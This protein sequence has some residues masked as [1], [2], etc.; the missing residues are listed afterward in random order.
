MTIRD[1]CA[2]IESWA[3]PAIAWEKDNV[4]LLVGSPDARVRKVLVCLDVTPEVVAEAVRARAGLIVSHHPLIF[5]PL[6]RLDPDTPRG[7]MIAALL[8]HGIGL[9]AAHTNLDFTAGGVSH[10]LAASLGLREIAP[11]APLRGRERKIAVFV[12]A[13]HAGGVMQAMAGAGAGVIGKYE[14][15]SFTTEG[16]G[17]FLAGPGSNPFIGKRGALERVGETKLEMS[18]PSWRVDAVVRAMKAAH[19]YDEVAFDVYVLENASRDH[20]MGAVGS[21]RRPLGLRAF[22]KM[23]SVRLGARALRYSGPSGAR[24]RRVA[25]CGGS[26]SELLGDA[27]RSGAD[28]FVTADVRYHAFDEAPREI[29]LVDA[30]HFE[31][32]RPAVGALA[33]Y[34]RGRPEVSGGRV[35]VIE[36]KN[37][38]NPVKYF[39]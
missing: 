26:G 7:K 10:I 36:S 14:S 31:T 3:P 35:A 16:S 22:L 28:A 38:H 23:V 27:L 13:S 33:S 1:L 2:L 24:I 39:R 6:R 4:G 25:V 17:S 5:T 18:C 21:L 8:R 32:E 19:P 30:G 34:L 37:S 12:P 20:G 29:V 9:C 11:L 15:C